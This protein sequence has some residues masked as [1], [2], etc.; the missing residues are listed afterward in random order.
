MAISY[1]A[2]KLLLECSNIVKTFLT[3]ERDQN[4]AKRYIC[5]VFS[6]CKTKP[7]FCYR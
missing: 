1:E 3:S 4:K 7:L 5:N 6:A 2:I